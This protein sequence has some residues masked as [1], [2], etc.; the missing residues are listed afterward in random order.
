MSG[1]GIDR[2]G[3]S[4]E[5]TAF[6]PGQADG[7]PLGLLPRLSLRQARVESRIARTGPGVGVEAAV[8]WLAEALGVPVEVGRPEAV[9]RAAGLRRS[10]LV[11]QWAWARLG[12]QIAVGIETPLAHAIVDRLLGFDRLPVEGRLPLSPVEWGVLTFVCVEAVNR[13]AG[14][15]DG[16]F[17]A[18]DFTVERV[19]PDPFDTS[20]IGRVVTLRWPL[21]VGTVDGSVRLW[22]SEAF[23]T[24]WLAVQPAAPPDVPPD[25]R[26]K[27]AGLAGVWHAEAGTI[28]LP[29]GLSTVRPG[30][31]LPLAATGLRGS[32][33]SP[34]GPVRLTLR[35]G[36][37]GGTFHIDA[38]PVPLSGG[39]RLSVTAPFHHEPTPR[40][41]LPVSPTPTPAHP[42][43]DAAP[44]PD[45]P[46]TLAVELGRV[47]LTLARL[48]DLRPG[49][50][51][52]LGR[53]S[54]EP[55]ELTSGG[56]LVARGELVQIDTE[57]GVRVTHVFL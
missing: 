11:A 31:V 43:P 25:R 45:V 35:L 13:L 9:W 29:R 21:R 39:A 30:G 33:A 51:V 55:V 50:V 18:W 5:I 40:E 7:G 48:A 20:A 3:S 38:E 24:R 42:D 4:A 49:D 34:A 57:L 41:A 16:P 17:G 12:T 2:P 32:P 23:L 27:L 47:N 10:G 19:G 22:L 6:T 53:H 54:R 1:D 8:G 14:A 56:R 15:G 46:V 28:D 26:A 52:E 44:A 36:G 37:D